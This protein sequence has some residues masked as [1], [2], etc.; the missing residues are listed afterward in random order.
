[1][2]LPAGA[3]PIY[4][5]RWVRIVAILIGFLIILPPLMHMVAHTWLM[6]QGLDVLETGSDWPRVAQIV[7]GAAIG[8]PDPI[9]RLVRGW[10]RA[11]ETGERRIDGRDR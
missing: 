4:M 10:R 1:M 8:F 11:P 2:S 7:I 5:P 9:V 6:I 3:Q